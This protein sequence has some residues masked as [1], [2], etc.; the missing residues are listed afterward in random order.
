MVRSI[1]QTTDNAVEAQLNTIRE[2][3]ADVEA[4][5]RLAD[6]ESETFQ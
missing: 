6:A 3:Q 2:A 1:L 4:I 5:A